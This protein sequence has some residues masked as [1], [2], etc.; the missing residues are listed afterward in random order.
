MSILSPSAP[1]SQWEALD[2]GIARSKDAIRHSR[3]L[4]AKLES[5]KAEQRLWMLF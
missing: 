1:V 3:E 4:L 2:A 5:L